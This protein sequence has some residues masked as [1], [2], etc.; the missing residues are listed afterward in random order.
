MKEEKKEIEF[1]RKMLIIN[2]IPECLKVFSK[3][4]LI[5]LKDF[6]SVL[7]RVVDNPQSTPLIVFTLCDSHERSPAF[8]SRI[9]S[10]KLW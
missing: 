2:G 10:P 6:N 5:L 3:Q 7:E 9:F 1:E 4:K 8:L